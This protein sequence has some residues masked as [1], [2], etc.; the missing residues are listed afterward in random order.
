MRDDEPEAFGVSDALPLTMLV[1]AKNAE[2]LK[3]EHL[4]GQQ[5]VVLID[6]MINEGR[7]MI[8]FFDHIRGLNAEIQIVVVSGVTQDQAIKKGKL[9]QTLASDSNFILI[10]L[11][12]SGD[13]YKGIDDTDTGHRLFNATAFD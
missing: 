12:V 3:I 13:K 10:S 6:S 5:T 11:R 7:S 4:K 2:N 1:H 8:E 9:A